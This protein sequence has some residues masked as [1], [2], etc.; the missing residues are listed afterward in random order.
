MRAFCKAFIA[1]SLTMVVS[2][3]ALADLPEWQTH[4]FVGATELVE[5]Q[6]GLSL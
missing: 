1:Y 6:S 3:Q 5:T 4:R 2:S